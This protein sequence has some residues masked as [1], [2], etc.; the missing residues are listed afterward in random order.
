[1]FAMFKN[2]Y[3]IFV[4]GD[5][6]KI[7]MVFDGL[8]VGGI[9]RVGVDYAR[10]LT[11]MGHEVHL[12][13]L[14]PELAELESA[15]LESSEIV[16][17]FYPRVL[18]PEQFSVLTK[19]T[20]WGRFAYPVIYAGLTAVNWAYKLFLKGTRREFREEYDLVIAFSGHYNDLTFAVKNFLKARKKMAWVHGAFYQYVLLSDGFVR[21]YNKIRNLVVLSDDGQTEALYNHRYLNLNISKL[22]NPTF[23]SSRTVSQE[24]VAELG[25][26]YGK[27]IVMVSRLSYP[28][29]DPY[30]VVKAFALLRQKYGQDYNLV[31]VGD[32]PERAPLEKFVAEQGQNLEKHVFFAGTCSDVQNYYSAAKLFV[33]ASLSGEG[34]PTNMIEALSYHLPQVVTDVKVGPREILGNSEFGLLCRCG[35]PEDMAGNMNR[36][37]TDDALYK[38]YQDKSE[39]RFRDFLPDRIEEQLSCVLKN[40]MDEE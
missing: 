3:K 22:Y 18:A 38:M 40:V 19:R 26:Q 20:A 15:F 11:K 1:M 39:S 29:K 31:F 14:R 35:D 23:I 13:N 34:L 32:G 5:Y 33:H 7:A 27:F 8:Q 25:E 36:M 28:E 30:T 6:M 37:L 10:L 16:H 24:R 9:E 21:L 4:K 17:V 12:F 2:S